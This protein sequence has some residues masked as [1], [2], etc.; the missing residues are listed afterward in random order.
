MLV[1]TAY[2]GF[3]E[4]DCKA[5]TNI[6]LETGLPFLWL[7]EFLREDNKGGLSSELKD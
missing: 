4:V 6:C 1:F 2:P 7:Q 5:A 3:L